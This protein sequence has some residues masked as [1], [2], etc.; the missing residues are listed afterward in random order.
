MN[1]LS[2]FVFLLALTLPVA[3]CAQQIRHSRPHSDAPDP[4]CTTPGVAVD[5]AFAVQQASRK[6]QTPHHT[7]T[8]APQSVQAVPEGF[9]VRML[10][11]EP[12][13]LMGGGGLVWV[14]GETG[15]A[16]VLIRYE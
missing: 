6:L 15:C 7:W 14:D 10:V 4:W 1:R 12:R 5:S 16:I 3:A 2:K 13:G 9:L 8:F 11:Q